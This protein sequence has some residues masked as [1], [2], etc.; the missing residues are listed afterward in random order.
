MIK[1]NVEKFFNSPFYIPLLLA[2]TLTCWNLQQDAA[3]VAILCF[4]AVLTLVC[5][6]DSSPLVPIAMF[7]TAIFSRPAVQL[8][9][10]LM[11][12][13]VSPPLLL[14][15][16][17]HVIAYKPRLKAGKYFWGLL[18]AAIGL[19]LGGLL[20]DSVIS[21]FLT[22][23]GMGFLTLFLYVFFFSTAKN[24][25]RFAIDG[26]TALSLLIIFQVALYYI[27]A[28]D[29]EIAFRTKRIDLGWG[30]SNNA[31]LV[32]SMLL[33]V[34]FYKCTEKKWSVL[35][36]LAAIAQYIAVL[37]TL[38][39][40]N[41]L[42]GG[43]MF[44][45]LLIITFFFCKSRPLYLSCLAAAG[46]AA[47]AVI[48]FAPEFFATVSGK[49]TSL[50]LDDNG[51]FEL[52][53]Q[54]FDDFKLNPLFGVGFF[55]NY[56][57][58][59]NWYHNTVLQVIGSLGIVGTLAFIPFFYQRYVMVFKKFNLCN[60]YMLCAV[61]LS[62]L[63][64]LVDCNFFFIYNAIFTVFIYIIIESETRTTDIVARLF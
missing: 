2:V 26:F 23:A 49:L 3:G 5:G 44:V 56:D 60:F 45:P 57:V 6:R 35:F 19:S 59:P 12:Y 33:P 29:F 10:N 1:K 36:L 51:R 52:F 37:F 31:G 13:I 64:G 32:L 8:D 46:A 11:L 14:S 4:F 15:I 20:F 50:D 21:H 30:N 28:P 9:I 38:S 40:G 55:H 16:I 7:A 17:Y 18:L 62:A 42:F 34:T 53:V 48:L 43:L 39:R 41:M 54:A 61:V 22:V 25:K 63:Y 47:L 58:I 27:K 24:F